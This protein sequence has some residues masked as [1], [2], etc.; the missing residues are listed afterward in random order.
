MILRTVLALIAGPR[1]ETHASPLTLGIESAV[2]EPKIVDEV[3]RPV[4][5]PVLAGPLVELVIDLAVLEGFMQCFNLIEPGVFVT[6]VDP[7]LEAA[8]PL[9]ATGQGD[10]IVQ[11]EHAAG[12]QKRA[13]VIILRQGRAVGSHYAEDLRVE[14]RI[15]ERPGGAHGEPTDGAVCGIGQ[16]TVVRVD[17][18]HQI[19]TGVVAVLGPPSA[20]FTQ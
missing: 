11:G 7:D 6:H 12:A 9:R 3:L 18:L 17:M 8:R 19:G 15:V 5:P 1:L 13:R 14:E 2:V 16:G 4:A 10:G 20:W